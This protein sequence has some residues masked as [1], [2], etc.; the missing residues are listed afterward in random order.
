MKSILED[1]F[2]GKISPSTNLKPILETYNKLI[3][4]ERKS[5]EDLTSSLS[6]EQLKL[7]DDIMDNLMEQ[8]PR[9]HAEYFVNGF[10]LGMLITLEVLT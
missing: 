5:N 1:L 10:K 6:C 9:A 4:K 8:A 7:F 2:D 3:E